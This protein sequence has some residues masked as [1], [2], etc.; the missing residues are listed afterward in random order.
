MPRVISPKSLAKRGVD[1]FNMIAPH[2]SS[3]RVI[4]F[5]VRPHTTYDARARQTCHSWLV[6]TIC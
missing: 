4:L 1:G 5:R 6:L 3:E 2:F